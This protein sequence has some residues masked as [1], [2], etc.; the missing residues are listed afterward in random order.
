LSELLIVAVG[1]SFHIINS[2]NI[3]TPTR[4]SLCSNL[5]CIKAVLGEAGLQTDEDVAQVHRNLTGYALGLE[6]CDKIGRDV[7]IA[8]RRNTPKGLYS[9]PPQKE[10]VTALFRWICEGLGI[11]GC[12]VLAMGLFIMHLGHDNFVKMMKLLGCDHDCSDMEALLKIM[13]REQEDLG[14]M[15]DEQRANI[16][17]AKTGRK[18]SD[19]HRASIAAALTGRKQ[20]DEQ[21]A[22]ISAATTGRKQSDEQRANI[23]AATTGRKQSDDHRAKLAAG[24][25]A[26][27]ES[28]R[29][30]ELERMRKDGETIVKVRSESCPQGHEREVALN[31]YNSMVKNKRLYCLKCKAM[32]C[33]WLIQE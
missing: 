23:S 2:P 9:G 31:Y 5:L 25:A 10:G 22:N 16:S 17:A 7:H 20:S 8:I 4:I 32:R 29:T 30:A 13:K 21:R 19:D 14:K 26:G 6:W 33:R 18:Q 11:K 12:N 1:N 27:K 24:I 15:S 3:S 28:K